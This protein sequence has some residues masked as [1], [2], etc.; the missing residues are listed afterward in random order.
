M[1]VTLFWM[2]VASIVYGVFW[3]VIL[4]WF[5]G[6]PFTNYFLAVCF[7]PY[8]ILGLAIIL[9]SAQSTQHQRRNRED[10]QHQ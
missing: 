1:R 5:Y 3:L 2:G 7:F 4:S 6:I 9:D 8:I 10:S